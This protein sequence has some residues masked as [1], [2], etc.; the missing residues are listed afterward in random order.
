MWD[1]FIENRG[2]EMYRTLTSEGR[3][4]RPNSFFVGIRKETIRSVDFRE[5]LSRGG[6]FALPVKFCGRLSLL[7]G[8]ATKVGYFSDGMLVTFTPTPGGLLS[9]RGA[10]NPW[11]WIEGHIWVN[12]SHG[13]IISAGLLN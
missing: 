1:Q 3:P 8:V 10:E 11:G 7:K 4:A 13:E 12:L 6:E 5:R 9:P 2:V